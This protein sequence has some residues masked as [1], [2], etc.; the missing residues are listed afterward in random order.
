MNKKNKEMNKITKEEFE[1]AKNIIIQYMKQLEEEGNL[2][3]K[4]KQECMFDLGF[5]E[6][7]FEDAVDSWINKEKKRLSIERFDLELE[8]DLFK[9]T[10]R[11]YNLLTIDDK[12]KNDL[13]INTNV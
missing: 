1:S 3:E 2:Y 12:I 4:I 9:T 8:K 11:G 6:Q 5:S 13:N 7:E 10:K